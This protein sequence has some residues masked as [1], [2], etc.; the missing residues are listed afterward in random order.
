MKCN[1]ES[2][3]DFKRDKISVTDL[4]KSVGISRQ[5]FYAYLRNEKEPGVYTAIKITDY[6]NEKLEENDGCP[7]DLYDISQFWSVE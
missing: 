4:C 2:I 6:L 5:S 7:P 1:I 3:I